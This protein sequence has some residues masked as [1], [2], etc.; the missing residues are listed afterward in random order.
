MNKPLSSTT[1]ELNQSLQKAL[2]SSGLNEKLRIKARMVGEDIVEA[3]RLLFPATK[4]TASKTGPW[5]WAIS[6][7]SP[8]LWPGVFGTQFQFGNEFNTQITSSRISSRGE[9]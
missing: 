8:G 2:L 1:S 9:V 6:L 4:M 3:N 7:T 5:S